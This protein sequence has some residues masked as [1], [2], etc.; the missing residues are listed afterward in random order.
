MINSGITITFKSKLLR[1]ICVKNMAVKLPLFIFIFLPFLLHI[2]CQ[3]K[4]TENNDGLLSAD[5]N[6][7]QLECV[8]S[9]TS[10]EH[11]CDCKNRKRV[12]T[13]YF[14]PHKNTVIL[15][16]NNKNKTCF[17]F[18]AIRIANV[19]WKYKQFD[20]TELQRSFGKCW[21]I[22]E[23]GIYSENTIQEY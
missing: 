7:T 6:R 15:N 4:E 2:N 18:T 11:I 8:Y 20:C 12:N 17:N 19:N 23:C 9:S 10:A 1:P 22:Y 14:L 3:D 16:I 21:N 13:G 5:P